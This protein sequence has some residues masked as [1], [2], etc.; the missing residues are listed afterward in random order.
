MMSSHLP[1]NDQRGMTLVIVLIFLMLLTMLGIGAMS[2]TTLQEKMAGNMK[3]QTIAF[4]SA[5]SAARFGESQ[6]RLMIERPIAETTGSNDAD[7]DVWPLGSNDYA[8]ATQAWW[9]ATAE[10]YGTWSVKDLGQT[11]A[12]PRYI[13]EYR[14]Q[15]E[16]DLSSESMGVSNPPQVYDV[17]GSGTGQTLNARTVV[18]STYIRRF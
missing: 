10:E 14:T 18:Q 4:Q 12:D 8:T 6:L 5:E 7:V 2:T 15:I 1:A 17:Y 13:V 3:D 16:D 9:T 11:A